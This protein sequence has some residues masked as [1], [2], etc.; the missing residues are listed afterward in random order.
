MSSSSCRDCGSVAFAE[1][2]GFQNCTNCG[3]CQPDAMVDVGPEWR[4]FSDQPDIGN[5]CGPPPIRP[6]ES[7]APSSLAIGS[8]HVDKN[9]KNLARLSQMVNT[10]K[11]RPSCEA[12]RIVMCNLMDKSALLRSA[13][14]KEKAT[15]L[16]FFFRKRNCVQVPMQRAAMALCAWNASQTSKVCCSHLDVFDV[17]LVSKTDYMKCRRVMEADQEVAKR[18]QNLVKESMKVEGSQV[19]SVINRLLASTGVSNQV[20]AQIK[21]YASEI[22]IK[23]RRDPDMQTRNPLYISIAIALIAMKAKLT[24]SEIQKYATFREVALVFDTPTAPIKTVSKD[25]EKM[26]AP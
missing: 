16:Y 4:T 18:I 25:L 3:L 9:A 19:P 7:S 11:E 5:R 10:K 1:M 6:S 12:E 20:R 21:K 14:V 15:E 22:E 13:D 2:D 23:V 24:E 26:V 17:F 8:C